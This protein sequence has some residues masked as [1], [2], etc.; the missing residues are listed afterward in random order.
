M[1]LQV[2]WRLLWRVHSHPP[3][4]SHHLRPTP[5]VRRHRHRL[6]GP[7]LPPTY[8][9]ANPLRRII[10]AWCLFH[11]AG[12]PSVQPR[13]REECLPYGDTISMEDLDGLPFLDMIVKE[14]FRLNPSIPTTVSDFPGRR[15]WLKLINNPRFRSGKRKRTTLFLS[16]NPSS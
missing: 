15:N 16:G 1:R 4:S 2:H 5:I 11:L 8:P 3:S 13:L 10:M 9:K 6:V 14:V 7:S 12:S